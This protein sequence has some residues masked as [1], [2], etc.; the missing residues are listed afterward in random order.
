MTQQNILT[1]LAKSRQAFMAAPC[2]SGRSLIMN[3]TS[4][5]LLFPL[6]TS[7]SGKS[8]EPPSIGG[9]FVHQSGLNYKLMVRYRDGTLV[10]TTAQL[11]EKIDIPRYFPSID[12][13]YTFRVPNCGDLT[14][15]EPS[16]APYSILMPDDAY[17]ATQ[18]KGC[19]IHF[20]AL[21][22]QWSIR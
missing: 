11:L 5:I 1:L 8:L 9:K 20:G 18:V 2:S 13:V 7:C 14:I 19:P 3:I 6:L 21:E 4:L 12:D 16:T 10:E 17:F 22:N 15:L